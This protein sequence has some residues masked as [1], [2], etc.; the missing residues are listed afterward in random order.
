MKSKAIKTRTVRILPACAAVLITLGL[1]ACG[2]SSSASSSGKSASTAN[3][4]TEKA[5]S[6]TLRVA[7]EQS[8]EPFDPATLGD[9]RS[10]ELAQNVFDG[11]TAIDQSNGSAVPAIAERWTI[12]PNGKVYTFFLRSGVKFQNGDPVTAQDF[13]YSWNRTLSPKTA[14]PY[15][16]FLDGIEGAE[17]VSGGKA[18]TAS[19]IKVL[20]PLELQVTLAA[21]AGYFLQLVSR[22]PFWVVDPK[23]VA[24]D[25]SHWDAPPDITGTG[26][27]QLTNQVGDTEYSFKANPTYFGG[28]PSIS[29]VKV[30]VVPN[31]TQR[32]ARYEAGEFDAVFGL[33]SAALRQVEGSS[34][35]KQQLHIKKQLGTTWM[36]MNNKV[37]P[38]NNQ[39]VRQAF[40]DAIDRASLVKVALDGLGA[41]TGTFLPPGLAGAIANTSEAAQYDKYDPSEAKKLLEEAGYPGGK[42]F[43]SVTLETQNTSSDETVTQF[44][45]AEL[46]QN[47]G[48]HINLKSVPQTA[49]NAAFESKTNPPSLYIYNFSLDYPDAQ[50]MLQYFTTSGPEGFVNYEHYENSAYNTLIEKAVATTEP[51]AR[52]SLYTEA[53]KVFMSTEPVVPLYNQEIAWLAKPYTKG[54]EQNSQYMEEWKQGTLAGAGG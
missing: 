12:S 3:S 11:L 13:A 53:E 14:S 52:A 50:E 44:I 9:N 37:K 23:V 20:G 42:G 33:A 16:F 41:P 19:G 32:V 43:P 18:K 26:A 45:Q 1:T 21:P 36:G 31:P 7:V 28:A 22:W 30:S 25:G 51:A 8:P 15:L 4:S 6:N 35:L 54:V 2:G 47:L 34:T 27:Y 24:A 48:I 10:I 39:K 17:A 40:A 38:F 5:P 49:F 29:Q 46:A